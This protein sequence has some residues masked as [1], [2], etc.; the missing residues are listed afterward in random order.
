MFEL[1]E[2]MARQGDRL[3]IEIGDLRE[4]IETCRND[5][6][7]KELSLSA[8]IRVLIKAGIKA[9]IDSEQQKAS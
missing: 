5:D 1:R 7:W 4:Q 9:E 8:K 2:E 3:T 6:A